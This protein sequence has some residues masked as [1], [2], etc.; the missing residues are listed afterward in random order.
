MDCME[1]D[2]ASELRGG[3]YS[4]QKRAKRNKCLLYVTIPLTAGLIICGGISAYKDS[5]RLV[6]NGVQSAYA[7]IDSAGYL[8]TV[9]RDSEAIEILGQVERNLNTLDNT[10]TKDTDGGPTPSTKGIG[11]ALYSIDSL[12]TVIEDSKK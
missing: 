3:H 5:Q 6:N 11:S 12:K 9:G 4:D 2:F 7:G 10:I 8:H 1:Y